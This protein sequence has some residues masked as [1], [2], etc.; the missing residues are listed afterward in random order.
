M[1]LW[2]R[3]QDGK[4]LLKVQELLLDGDEIHTSSSQYSG[5]LGEYETKE[6]ALEVFDEIQKFMQASDI[7]LFKNTAIDADVVNALR[8]SGV[9]IM[10]DQITTLSNGKKR[11][12]K[13]QA[14]LLH[15][16]VRIY[17]MPKE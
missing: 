9:L 8:K 3:T 14:E 12:K 13:A 6:R 11:T 1:D 4:Q 5:L 2:I 17:E 10:Y 7:L 15:L 16:S